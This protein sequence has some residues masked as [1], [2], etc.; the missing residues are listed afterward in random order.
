MLILME[1][2]HVQVVSVVRSSYN[3]DRKTIFR[4]HTDTLSG[5]PSGSEFLRGASCAVAARLVLVDSSCRAYRIGR[6][7]TGQLGLGDL[8]SRQHPVRFQLPTGQEEEK[9]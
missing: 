8:R 1:L 3:G 9:E 6:N 4:S 7:D 5:S 2:H